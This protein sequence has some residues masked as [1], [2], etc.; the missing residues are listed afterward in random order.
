[1]CPEAVLLLPPS[2]GKVGGGRPGTTYAAARREAG[3]NRFYD[4]DPARD[5][6]AGALAKH[7]ERA[8]EEDLEALFEAKGANLRHAVEANL[9]HQEA[10]ILPAIERYSGVLYDHLAYGEMPAR[11]QEG[12][13]ERAVLM[14]GL[15]GALAPGDL[16][17]DYKLRMDASLPGVGALAAFW[18]PHVSA[19]LA[20]L[21]KGRFV[22]NLLP[23]AHADAWSG[24]AE[25]AGEVSV[26]FV[27]RRNGKLATL[28]HWNK[29]L[30]GAFARHLATRGWGVASAEKFENDGYRFDP[31]QS[32]VVDGR[33]EM[34]FVKG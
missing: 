26:R 13:E 3:A 6:V 21:V 1:M 7:I 17:P 2:E 5:R 31:A 19:S 18:R 33:G 11:A 27:V 20:A 34:V 30:K 14:S 16:I 29:A 12:F 9:L 22:W 4:L 10:P 25:S 32:T 15:F 28:S 24:S 23:P 8:S